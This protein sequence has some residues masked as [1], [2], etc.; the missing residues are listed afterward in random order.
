MPALGGS[1]FGAAQG[2]SVDLFNGDAFAGYANYFVRETAKTRKTK[3][4]WS[5]LLGKGGSWEPN[6]GA[7]K[8]TVR[9]QM[10]ALTKQ[11]SSGWA[12]L[13]TQQPAIDRHTIGESS[14]DV[15]L[16]W[17]DYESPYISWQQ[18]VFK[19]VK[20]SVEPH[21]QNLELQMARDLDLYLRDHV[22]N[23]SPFVYV[24]GV[25]L[26]STTPAFNDQYKSRAWLAEQLTRC[27]EALTVKNL[28]KIINQAQEVIGIQPA[29]GDSLAVDGKGF[30]GKYKLLTDGTTML[31]WTDDP[32][33]QSL[34]DLQRDLLNGSFNGPIFGRVAPIAEQ[35]P[36]R[37]ADSAT[38][39][40]G[41]LD[42]APE[43]IS[44][45]GAYDG[46]EPVPNPAYGNIN[47][48]P[49]QISWFMGDS[50][51][52]YRSMNIMPPPSAFTKQGMF[53]NGKVE[54]IKPTV[55][56]TLNSAGA[57]I[58][59]G[60]EKG[61]LVQLI[62]TLATGLEPVCN[63]LILPVIHKRAVFNANLTA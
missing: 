12:L 17:K 63:R 34:K 19:L 27:T 30:T 9:A 29:E 51:M 32:W 48:S 33:V 18:D 4:V 14:R 45:L 40:A 22:F 7:I 58:T 24:C 39:P 62:S 1:T 44:E 41:T 26:V 5:N 10:G 3:W 47:T 60:N 25:G 50:K 57:A 35:M 46:G 54:L 21:R 55:I 38:D 37:F 2:D 13:A 53:W 6:M 23:Y 11:S 20:D 28:A 8:R 49:Y 61:R 56:T 59:R 43:L 16:E 31:S 36:R 52:A 42:H 15:Q